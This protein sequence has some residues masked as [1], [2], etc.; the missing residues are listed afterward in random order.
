M[1]G[2][3]KS[4]PLALERRGHPR[5]LPDD[6]IQIEL[7]AEG[8]R[9]H[10]TVDDISVRGMRLLTDERCAVGSAVALA[11][12]GA[13]D[14]RGICVWVEDGAFGVELVEPKREIERVL[15]CI[16]LMIGL[17]GVRR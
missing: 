7:E 15:Q 10:A 17:R 13:G 12:P 6:A 14:F 2:V 1:P 16:C 3:Q 9:F 5:Y 8:R 11:H 4:K